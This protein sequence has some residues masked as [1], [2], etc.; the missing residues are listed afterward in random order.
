MRLLQVPLPSNI[1][2]PAMEAM[3]EMAFVRILLRA[4]PNGVGAA[5]VMLIVIVV[6]SGR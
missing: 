2:V 3:W 1:S 5:M 4:V 6:N